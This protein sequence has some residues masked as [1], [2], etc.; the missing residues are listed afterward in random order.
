M[1]LTKFP[2][3]NQL[4][5][6]CLAQLFEA[7]KS[8]DAHAKALAVVKAKVNRLSCGMTHAEC[9]KVAQQLQSDH[10]K[11]TQHLHDLTANLGFQDLQWPIDVNDRYS[12]YL[13][14]YI[15]AHA[16]KHLIL[17]HLTRSRMN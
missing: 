10:Q 3:N 11:S 15:Q 9:L 7:E 1:R 12:P 2:D 8:C 4:A 16:M 13:K 6:K 14:L 17:Q 5:S